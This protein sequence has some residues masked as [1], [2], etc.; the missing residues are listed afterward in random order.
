MYKHTQRVNNLK[1]AI[2]DVL[3]PANKLEKHGK[4]ILKLNIGDPI[5]HGFKTPVNIQ[6][7]LFKAVKQGHN[8][9]SNK[10]D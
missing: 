4:K 10:E 2:R 1:Y 9:Y 6:K 3:I 5:T 8:G 7:A